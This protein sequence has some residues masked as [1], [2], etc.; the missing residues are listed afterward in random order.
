[1][2]P[3]PGCNPDISLNHIHHVGL[4]SPVHELQP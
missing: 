4:A 3:Q 1:M 2:D